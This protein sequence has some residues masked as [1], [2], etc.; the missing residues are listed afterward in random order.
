MAYT[1]DDVQCDT[2][3]LIDGTEGLEIDFKR[4]SFSSNK[5]TLKSE[6]LVAFANCDT[7]GVLLFGVDEI[8]EN[9][10]QKGKIFGCDVSDK[11]ITGIQDIASKCVPPIDI[12]I[13]IENKLTDKPIIRIDIPSSPLKP[14]CT[15]SGSYHIRLDSSTGQLFPEQLFQMFMMKES[16]SFINKYKKAAEE[17][18]NMIDMVI[19]DISDTNGKVE[20]IL[21]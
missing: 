14:H 21:N 11:V 6:A 16:N 20:K 7:G 10:V 2:Q 3:K 18:E 19:C 17:T 9:G 4:D 13:S 1:H 15:P 8:E 12:K 5:L